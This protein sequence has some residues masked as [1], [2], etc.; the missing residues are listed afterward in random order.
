MVRFVAVVHQVTNLNNGKLALVVH[1]ER[2][3]VLVRWLRRV[4]P[5]ILIDINL[6]Y[7]CSK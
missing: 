2:M 7:I 4:F 5:L 1:F 6:G 3:A